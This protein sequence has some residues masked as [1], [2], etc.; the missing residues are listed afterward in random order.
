MGVSNAKL[1]NALIK[2]DGDQA[3][4]GRLLGITRSAVCHRVA[5]NPKL[6]ALIEEVREE[7]SDAAESNVR[8]A[9]RLE[10]ATK[11]T[12]PKTS[13]WWLERKAKDRGYGGQSGVRLD[14]DQLSAIIAQ[15]GND[16]EALRK[17]AGGG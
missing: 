10:A 16:P 11:T 2:S 4:A 13:K 15:F 17:L 14:D 1:R 7:T 12:D 9:I 3:A 5:R 6:Q 8:E